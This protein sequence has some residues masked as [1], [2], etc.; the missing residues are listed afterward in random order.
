MIIVS[1]SDK[2]NAIYP[3]R[4]KITESVYAS[5]FVVSQNQYQVFAKA[6]GIIN[7]I[8]VQEGDVVKAGQ[9]L[10]SLSSDISKLS[11]DNAR[12]VSSNADYKQNLDKLREVELSIEQAKRKMDNDLLMLN[13]QRKLW[14]DQIGTQFELEQK[15][16]LY[17]NSKL[18]YESIQLRLSE[19]RKQLK[20]ADAQS[21]KSLSIS[22]AMLD[23]YTVKSEIDGKVFSLTREKGEMVSAQTPLALIGSSTSFKLLLQ[24]DEND[25]VKIQPGQNILLSMDSYQGQTFKA[26][27]VKINPL[28]NERTRTFEVEA[29]FTEAPPVLYPNLTVE[30]NIIL[31]SKESAITIPRK[32]LLTND[33]VLVGKNEKRKVKVGLKDFQKVEILEGL[34]EHD[35]IYSPE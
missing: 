17:T 6:N 22:K 25:I 33:S 9:P 4:E 8:W 10:F 18:A 28:M 13:R 15:E 34:S 1:C 30:A 3:T 16:L 7:K 35:Q 5:G 19:L 12:L 26:V 32:Y 27:V 24:I 2:K 11:L 14:A 23:D 29:S 20:F 21:S 31:R